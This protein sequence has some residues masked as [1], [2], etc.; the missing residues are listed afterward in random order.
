MTEIDNCL[1]SVKGICSGIA[2]SKYASVMVMYIYFLYQLLSY[3]SL[4]HGIYGTY[5]VNCLILV[6]R[7]VYVFECESMPLGGFVCVFLHFGRSN[8]GLRIKSLNLFFKAQYL[9]LMT[10]L[11]CVRLSR[12][13]MDM[14]GKPIK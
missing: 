4:Y 14:S 6:C 3:V 7:L 10:R 5:L 8:H 1:L 11:M 13:V 9:Q 12:C 2:Y